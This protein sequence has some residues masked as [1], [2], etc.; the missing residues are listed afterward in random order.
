MQNCIN[1]SCD[2]SFLSQAYCR[3]V[4]LSSITH[5]QSDVHRCLESLS[6][7][8]LELFYRQQSQIRSLLATETL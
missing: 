5:A 8:C 2:N 7:V 4:Y 3:V 1:N 6:T